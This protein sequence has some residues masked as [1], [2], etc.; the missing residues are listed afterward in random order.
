VGERP[1]EGEQVLVAGSLGVV[2]DLDDF[3]MARLMAADIL[4][5]RIVERAASVADRRVHHAWRLAKLL[6]DSPEASRSE[7][8]FLRCHRDRSSLST[9]TRGC[10]SGQ[11]TGV[12]SRSAAPPATCASGALPFRP[13]ARPA[14]SLA[15][16]VFTSRR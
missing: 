7:R 3:G 16:F 5:G 15:G 8:R 4:V 12:P 9:L 11:S 10:A 13:A 6:L 2:R 1:E 14:S